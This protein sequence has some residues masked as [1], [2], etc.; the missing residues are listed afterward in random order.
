MSVVPMNV[1]L[2]ADR[3]IPRDEAEAAR[4]QVAALANYMKEPPPGGIRLTL[5]RVHSG[6]DLA[7]RPYVADADVRIGGRAL[8]AHATGP[9]AVGA[10]Q[11]VAERLRR[12]IR[13]VV[14]ADVAQRNEP[15]AIRRALESLEPRRENRP[16]PRLKP[17]GE[18][19]IVHR[20]T[21][22]DVP[23]TTL[24]A[25][26]A[27]LDGDLDF[28]IFRHALTAEDVV[29][30]RRDDGR[31]GLIHP[32]GSRLAEDSGNAYVVPEPSRY[33]GPIKLDDARADMDE[34][35]H[36]FLYFVDLDDGR[37]KVLYLRHD[38]DYGL[39]EPA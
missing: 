16:Q 28:H 10:A 22:P 9:T 20:R 27:L 34:L 37:G 4:E 33:P 6:R 29:V 13:R 15:A 12:Q 26:H 18:R 30:Y 35:N 2:K 1:V 8:A 39:V 21:Y 38:G 3:E 14:D 5:R 31:I 17:P 32:P 11:E 36:R 25:V 24:D 19:R 7:K 23:Q